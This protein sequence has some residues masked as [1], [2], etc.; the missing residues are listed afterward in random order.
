MDPCSQE[1][2]YGTF[3]FTT[4]SSCKWSL[5]GDAELQKERLFLEEG[6]LAPGLLPA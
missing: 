2:E 3:V 5:T 1:E 4:G 6:R